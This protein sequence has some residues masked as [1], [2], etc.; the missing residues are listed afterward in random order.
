MHTSRALHL[1]TPATGEPAALDRAKAAYART[2]GLFH[3]HDLIAEPLL[4]RLVAEC[5]A[6]R[7]AATR[8]VLPGFK[9][10]GSVSHY[11]LLE[12]A[13][14]VRALHHSPELVGFLRD[15]TGLTLVPCPDD[16]PHA[17]A[18][19]VYS[20]AGDHIGWHYDTSHYAGKRITVLLGLVDRSSSRL[21]CELHTRGGARSSER[22]E[23]A[24]TPGTLVAFDGDTVF[25]AVSPVGPGE[26]RVV[27]SLE[28]V[29]STAMI[30][31]RKV[32]SF[33]KD[34]LAYFG[35][36]ALLKRRPRP[37]PQAST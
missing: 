31:P 28:Y 12:D 13:P 34:G 30:R 20:E 19:Y 26:E 14:A 1:D 32:V 7:G 33:L 22:V 5:G 2:G 29:T 37:A 24:T 27:L 4:A 11:R 3:Q 6:L 36:F 10:S 8:K 17:T 16:D 23:I 21:L 9:K 25:H 15:L 18:L 35:L